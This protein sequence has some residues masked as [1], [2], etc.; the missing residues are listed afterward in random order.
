[1]PTICTPGH[2]INVRQ[3]AGAQPDTLPPSHIHV[4]HTEVFLFPGNAEQLVILN[5][6]MVLKQLKEVLCVCRMNVQKLRLQPLPP[7]KILPL[8]RPLPRCCDGTVNG[9]NALQKPGEIPL[10]CI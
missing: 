1:M 8:P 4:A 6:I 9:E 2:C 5:T 7:R 3:Y 10:P